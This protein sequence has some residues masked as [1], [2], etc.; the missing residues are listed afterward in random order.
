VAKDLETFK[1]YPPSQR[2]ATFTIDEA[3]DKL[4]QASGQSLG[5]SRGI[6]RSRAALKSGLTVRFLVVP[7]SLAATAAPNQLILL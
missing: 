1:E 5:G 6:T 3:M 4:R 7:L 2:A